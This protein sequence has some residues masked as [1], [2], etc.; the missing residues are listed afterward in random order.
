[1]HW[2]A[3]KTLIAGS[4]AIPPS[5]MS[6]EISRP[7]EDDY[8]AQ[9]AFLLA[10]ARRLVS[11]ESGAEDLVQDTWLRYLRK[12]PSPGQPVR[13][14]L[15]RVLRNR[16][17]ETLRSRRASTTSEPEFGTHAPGPTPME[18]AGRQEFQQA[19]LDAVRSL[20]E[21]YRSVIRLRFREGLSARA[22][23]DRK[24]AS[25]E[26]IRSQLKRGLRMLR[27][28]LDRR[29]AGG[30]EEW[31]VAVLG[32]LAAERGT[33]SSPMIATAGALAVCAAAIAVSLSVFGE[34][35]ESALP[36][37]LASGAPAPAPAVGSVP[38]TADRTALR[39]ASGTGQLVVSVRLAHSGEPVR[40][41][42]ATVSSAGEPLESATADDRGRL[43]FELPLDRTVELEVLPSETTE[44]AHVQLERDW[45]ARTAGELVVEVDAVC[46]VHGVVQTPLEEPVSGVLVRAFDG[47]FPNFLDGA[48]L[49]VWGETRTDA[50]GKF[51]LQRVPIRA[52]LLATDEEHSHFGLFGLPRGLRA[53]DYLWNPNLPRTS[54]HYLDAPGPKVLRYVKASSF[55]VLVL[56][57][58]GA[59]LEG[60]R[61]DLRGSEFTKREKL[62]D[63]TGRAQFDF[64]VEGRTLVLTVSADGH[65]YSLQGPFIYRF[66]LP[67]HVV[68]LEP[69]RSIA[70]R[71]FDASG[72]PAR[73]ASVRAF[74]AT[75]TPAGSLGA[76][77]DVPPRGIEGALNQVVADAAGRFVFE[78][79][80]S[81]AFD[82]QALRAGIV[83][84]EGQVAPGANEVMLHAS[85]SAPELRLVGKIRDA[86]SGALVKGALICIERRR[87]KFDER[88]D[89]NGKRLQGSDFDLAGRRA[90]EW[91][92]HVS[93][94]GYAPYSSFA[95]EFGP[96]THHVD[97][98]LE[99]SRDVT[100][101]L[102]DVR[103]APAAHAWVSAIR[104][105]RFEDG[106]PP[107]QV[108]CAVAHGDANGV[109]VLRD[110]PA[111]DLV[112]QV[113][114]PYSL[115]EF[116]FELPLGDDSEQPVHLRIDADCSTPRRTQPWSAEETVTGASLPHAAL[117]NFVLKVFDTEGVQVLEMFNDQPSPERKLQVRYRLRVPVERDGAIHIEE[118]EPPTLWW[119][120]GPGP[121]FSDGGRPIYPH[122]LLPAGRHRLELRSDAFEPFDLW[123][124][125]PEVPEPVA[126]LRLVLTP[127][128]DAGP[129]EE[130]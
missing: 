24:G 77:A 13:P 98:E 23:A 6:P 106:R 25:I 121:L 20:R 87:G 84:A 56:G 10:L 67:E 32:M 37:H 115:H 57:V 29:T 108:V 36:A 3:G 12:P 73:G 60:A 52:G 65:A 104:E 21:P 125:V 8:H 117:Q 107:E 74:R 127:L 76:Q 85:D 14:W 86:R 123:I 100:L 34:R 78:D 38:V 81:G 82:V 83:F 75:P 94:E 22:I 89:L 45:K 66:D 101:I 27:E 122:L 4:L 33:R 5:R 35:G 80:G 19:L 49:H 97:L 59:P 44:A 102:S 71:V 51:T 109:A 126:P 55:R 16:F 111:T 93:A 72:A 41:V 95:Y 64:L 11:S 91:L 58:D 47:P 110:V 96:G 39:G 61:L 40:G 130:R 54:E 69:A 53:D 17:F 9:H 28:K 114:A 128:V 1:M 30:R 118:A 129:D 7:S 120:C 2:L 50:A 103:E 99:P 112:L 63:A 88:V 42:E 18:L 113:S 105:V 43:A 26:T 15:A 124:T 48:P 68:R 90:G 70:G 92:I 119:W 46:E 62:T 79:L 116:P 31:T